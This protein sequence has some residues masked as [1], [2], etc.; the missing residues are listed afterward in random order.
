MK[1]TYANGMRF[2]WIAPQ[3]MQKYLRPSPRPQPPD[4]LVG[5]LQRETSSWFQT[6]WQD[7]YVELI[8][9]FLMWWESVETAR[10]GA[11]PA[12][13]LYLLGLDLKEKDQTDKAGG[14]SKIVKMRTS[15]SQGAVFTF[16][17]PD[18]GD[19]GDWADGL[20]HHAGYCEELREF[21]QAQENGKE[22]RQ[23]LLVVVARK[24]ASAP[25]TGSGRSSKSGTRLS[26]SQREGRKSVNVNDFL[27]G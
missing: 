27:A 11:K 18:G 22:T 25:P 3:Q 15:S 1:V 17:S 23:E 6:F 7:I 13:S 8:K 5:P 14:I 21:H 16:K 4:P 24:G 9:G 26:G 19:M 12:G 10:T 2:K 20:W